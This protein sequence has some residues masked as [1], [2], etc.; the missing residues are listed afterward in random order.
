[1]QRKRRFG[2]RLLPKPVELGK[3]YEVNIE[4]ISRK[5][6]GIARIR[7]FV[8]FVPNT[9]PGD[10]VRIRITRVSERFAE[11]EVVETAKEE[12]E[13]EWEI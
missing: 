3:E 11:G 4:E 1:V 13:D 6:Q 12:N 7:G 9:K 2:L 8:I 10:H 5:G